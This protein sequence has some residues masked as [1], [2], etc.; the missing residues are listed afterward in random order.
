VAGLLFFPGIFNG[1]SQ[2]LADGDFLPVLGFSFTAILVTEDLATFFFVICMHYV[3]IKFGMYAS[4]L[5]LLYMI[6]MIG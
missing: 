6:Q 4:V 1:V 5:Y 2:S 3:L